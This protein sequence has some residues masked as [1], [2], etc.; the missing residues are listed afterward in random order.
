MIELVLQ[1][2]GLAAIVAAAGTAFA[3]SADRIA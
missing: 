1:F 3:L 2:L